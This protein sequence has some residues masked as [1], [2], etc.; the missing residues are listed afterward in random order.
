MQIVADVG[1]IPG[2][3]CRGFC[4]YCYFRKVKGDQLFGCSNCLPTKVGCPRCTKGVSESQNEFRAPFEVINEVQSTLLMQPIRDNKL[5]ANI[6]GGGDISCYPHLEEL[7]AN[8]NQLSLSTHLGYTSGK[9]I[10]NHEI[11]NKLINNGVDE[12]TFTIFADDVN[13]RKEWLKDPSPDESLKAAQ[14][15]AENTELHAATVIIPGVNDGDILKHTCETLESWGAK[16]LILMRF[17]NTEKEGLILG[18]EPI[19]KDYTSQPI[20]EF[21][22]LVKKIDCEY[23]LRVTGTPL[24]DFKTCTPFAI[25]KDKNEIFLQFIQKVTGEATI[26]SSKIA[27][28]YIANIFKKLGADE[29]NV[30]PVEKEIACLITKKDLEELDLSEVKESVIIPGRSFVH[31]LD[32]EKILSSDGT[33][34]IVGRGPDTLTVDGELSGTMTDEDVIERELEQFNELVEAINFFGMKKR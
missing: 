14:I 4:K 16:A 27:T 33:E 23:N 18:N 1:G 12:V 17:A 22:D 6:T 24:S 13:L 30:L 8:L 29:V 25:A 3:D 26:I 19:I 21:E 32:A 9:G 10:D 34:R 11:A 31:Q 28:P 5:K 2:K 20:N 7:T 15:F